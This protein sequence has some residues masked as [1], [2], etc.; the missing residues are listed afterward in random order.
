MHIGPTTH[1][2]STSAKV[3]TYEGDYQV[4]DS[5]VIW[6]VSVTHAEEPSPRRCSGSVPLSSPA[7]AVLAEES[8]RDAIVREIDGFEGDSALGGASG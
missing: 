5:E 1:E 7:T 6:Q 4:R 2:H 3:Y 8:V